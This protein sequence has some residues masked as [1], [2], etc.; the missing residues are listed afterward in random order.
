MTV[1]KDLLNKSLYLIRKYYLVPVSVLVGLMI[2]LLPVSYAFN[3]TRDER[4]NL[5]RINSSYIQ[6][7]D[8]AI[9]FGAGILK[10]GTPT[11]YLKNRLDTALQLYHAARIKRILVSGDSS[12]RGFNEPQ[13]MQQ[14]LVTQGIPREKIVIDYFGFDT[15]DTCWRAKNIY[16]VSHALVVTQAYHLP[17][18]VVTCR[19][20]GISTIGVQALTKGRDFTASYIIREVLAT[21]KM[22]IQ[23]S[24]D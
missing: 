11:P 21:N 19:E 9:V 4:Y 23:L 10:N 17:R 7:K 22:V 3:S 13:I 20:I 5:Q 6:P 12:S 16:K 18:A 15:Y 1:N 14:Y 24:S 2:V 8:N